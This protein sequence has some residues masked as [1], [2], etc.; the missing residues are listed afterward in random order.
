MQHT[1]DAS[2]RVFWE[3]IF[4]NEEFNK[5]QDQIAIYYQAE[6]DS[7]DAIPPRI[8]TRPTRFSTGYGN[9]S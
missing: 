6:S 3:K 8:S 2:V 9:L 4:A 5:K 1:I 7:L